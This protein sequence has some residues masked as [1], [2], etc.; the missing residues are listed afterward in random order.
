[1]DFEDDKIR[2]TPSFGGEVKPLVPCR[3]FM[4]K[5]PTSTT[6]ASSAKFNGHVSHPCST[7]FATRCLLALLT[8]VSGG[9]IRMTRTR[10]IVG[11]ITPHRTYLTITKTRKGGQGPIRA[12]VPLMMMVMMMRMWTGFFRLRIGSNDGIQ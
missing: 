4:L 2:S 10:F 8:D 12:V 3:R 1:M 7:C 5:N 9:R 6:D 11:L